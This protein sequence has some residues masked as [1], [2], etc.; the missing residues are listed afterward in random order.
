MRRRAF[1]FNVAVG[2][3]AP[4]AAE[5]QK[6]AQGVFT[7]VQDRIYRSGVFFVVD[8][9][10]E[11]RSTSRVEGVEVLVEFYN[12]FDELL[13]VEQGVLGPSTLG[14]GR[15]AALR[16][17][18]P[19]GEALRAETL[20]KLHYRF[21]WTQSF[22]QIQEVQRREVWTIGSPTRAL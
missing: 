18:T 15:V 5:A 17:V 8:A 3:V 9:L 21:T 14:P 7:I 1:L 19:Y 11:N 2:L 13:R 16:A 10:V 12:F 20:R 4:L 22:Q 6:E